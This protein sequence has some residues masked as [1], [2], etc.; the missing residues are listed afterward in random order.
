MFYFLIGFILLIVNSLPLEMVSSI[1]GHGHVLKWDFCVCFSKGC[2][3]FVGSGL[4]L[5]S[6]LG[7][8]FL[9]IFSLI[10]VP[11]RTSFLAFFPSLWAKFVFI[12]K[13]V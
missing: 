2:R 3:S 9:F 11:M 1:A 5:Y 7:L 10:P 4:V 13:M 6:S 12:L 8:G